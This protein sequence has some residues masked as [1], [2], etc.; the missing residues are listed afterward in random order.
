MSKFLISQQS[1]LIVTYQTMN[2]PTFLDIDEFFSSCDISYKNTSDVLLVV[3]ILTN[4][5]YFYELVTCSIHR[6]L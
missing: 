3:N 1:L 5:L 4:L 6:L 2:K